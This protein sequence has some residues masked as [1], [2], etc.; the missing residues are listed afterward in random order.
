V[1]LLDVPRL[2]AQLAGLERRVARG[3]RDTI[4]HA[5]GGH[6]DLANAA[7]GALIEAMLPMSR[8]SGIGQALTMNRLDGTPAEVRRRILAGEPLSVGRPRQQ[9]LVRFHDEHSALGRVTRVC[10]PVDEEDSD[11][12]M[13]R[14]PFEW[15]SD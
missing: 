5:P 9:A 12:L 13:D 3:G 4:D 6:D 8:A 7:C 11:A 14:D 1:E 10:R 2:H 15:E